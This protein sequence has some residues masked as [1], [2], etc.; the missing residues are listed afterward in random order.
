MAIALWALIGFFCAL[1]INRAADCWLN[2]DRLQCGLT[3]HPLR[4]TLVVVGVPV[5]FMLFAGVIDDPNRLLII[6]ASATILVLLLVIDLEQ[7]RIP[8]VVV[9]PTIGFTLLAQ[10]QSGQ[11]AG[12][13]AGMVLA[14]VVFWILYLIGGYVYGPGTLGK[15]D[16][17]LAALLGAMLGLPLTLFALVLGILLAGLS[18]VALLSAGRVTRQSTIPYGA[19]LAFAGLLVLFA[20]VI[21]LA[22]GLSF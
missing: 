2:P 21:G 1:L 17:K 11:L 16:V 7:M 22:G 15:G 20:N 4:D 10:W 5:L 8:D 3:K 18:S 12:A 6:C 13:M 9:F 19:Y 14:F